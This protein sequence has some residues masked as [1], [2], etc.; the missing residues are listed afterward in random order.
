MTNY[1]F[2]ITELQPLCLVLNKEF[3][4]YCDISLECISKTACKLG[5]L[6]SHVLDLRKIFKEI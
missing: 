3:K 6:K 1:G 5:L 4:E 2:G